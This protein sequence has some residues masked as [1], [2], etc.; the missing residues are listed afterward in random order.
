MLCCVYLG[1]RNSALDIRKLL[2]RKVTKMKIAKKLLAAIVAVMLVCSLA[3]CAFA[4]TPESAETG[5]VALESDWTLDSQNRVTVKLYFVEAEDL[6]SW[7][8][9]VNYDNTIFAAP[10]SSQGTDTKQVGNCLSNS[11]TWE[12]NDA[13]DDNSGKFSG[14]FKETLWSSEKFLEDSDPDSDDQCIV[15]STKFHALTLRFK[16]NDLDKFNATTTSITIANDGGAEDSKMTFNGNAKVVTAEVTHVVEVETPTEAPAT[17]APATEAPA[18]EAPAT[19]APATEAPATEAPATEAPA[20]EAPATRPVE[21]DDD[22]CRPG[23]PGHDNC[24]PGK[25]SCKPGKPNHNHPNTGDSAVLA[26]AA[27]VVLLAGAAFVVS[28]KRK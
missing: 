26:A 16:V 11:V 8:L 6:Y 27:G 14:F 21:D 9:Y 19:E 7:D 25:P 5:A 23:K 2:K 24:K 12:F 3:V 15:N 22:D 1:L 13:W 17:E 20:T 28:K 10:T 18:T 4:S